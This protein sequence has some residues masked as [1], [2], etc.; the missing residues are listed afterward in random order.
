M[1]ALV[2]IIGGGQLA[3][4]TAIAAA[5]LGLKTA[6]F[7]PEPLAPAFEVAQAIFRAQYNDKTILQRFARRCDVI[8]CEFE[9][10]P[11]ETLRIVEKIKPLYPS[12]RAFAIA[13]NRIAEKSF[14]EQCQL[15]TPPWQAVSSFQNN[16]FNLAHA[17]KK[18]GLPA[19]LKSASGGY[20]G[21][22]QQLISR[23]EQAEQ[24]WEAISNS[25]KITKQQSD[26]KIAILEK[27]LNL[28]S[29]FSIIAA[30]STN[31]ECECFPAT[32]NFH[33][34]G[35]LHESRT[36]AKISASLLARAQKWTKNLV[37]A[38]DIV[39]LLA[40]EFF[41][42]QD[43][44]LFVNEMAPRPHNSGHWT[45]DAAPTS[46]F[47]QLLRAILG[48]KLA[49][50]TPSANARMVNLLGEAWQKYP[51]YLAMPNA[52]VH[53]YAKRETRKGRKMG[54]VTFRAFK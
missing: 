14:F 32:E 34:N 44:K 47:E 22:N 49:K 12:A 21:K 54:H 24:A 42:T 1:T 17:I 40:V 41:V 48:W 51:E 46:Q 13:Q 20:D 19:L 8:T 45:I 39:G 31:G 15:D 27:H 6:I 43:G 28:L 2:G 50:T 38:L 33:K 3:R 30:R 25:I 4:M 52:V 7:A 9:N 23:P 26:D 37:D 29:E 16:E 10:I 18:I 36:P 5:K 53:L 11:L 35:I